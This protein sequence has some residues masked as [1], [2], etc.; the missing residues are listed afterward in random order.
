MSRYVILVAF[1]ITRADGDVCLQVGSVEK[2]VCIA[3]VLLPGQKLD[4]EENIYDC[5]DRFLGLLERELGIEIRVQSHETVV[6]KST[7]VRKGVR[8]CYIRNIF[9]A[10]IYNEEWSL[11]AVESVNTWDGLAIPVSSRDISERASGRSIR[12]S[13]S[14]LSSEWRGRN[15]TFVEVRDT[16]KIDVFRQ[17][18]TSIFCGWVSADRVAKLQVP[19]PVIKTCIE[20]WMSSFE[21]SCDSLVDCRD[22]EI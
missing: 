6:D 7:S 16:F 14:L 20:E 8:T 5:K 17:E 15:A 18:E 10:E 1:H 21:H 4:A 3:D 19:D 11:S 2:G 12:F 13:S 22:I 9:H